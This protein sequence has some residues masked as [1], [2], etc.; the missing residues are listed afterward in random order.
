MIPKITR[1]GFTL[2]CKGSR[3]LWAMVISQLRCNA[4]L[5]S[6]QRLEWSLSHLETMGQPAVLH[7]RLSPKE[8]R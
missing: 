5:S 7:E 1:R 4:E 8:R 2:F 6:R 3:N